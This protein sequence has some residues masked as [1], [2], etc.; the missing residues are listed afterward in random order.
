MEESYCWKK[1]LDDVGNGA[2]L[3]GITMAWESL[4]ENQ[5]KG[6]DYIK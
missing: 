3:D 5:L 6:I 2:G 1:I 4:V